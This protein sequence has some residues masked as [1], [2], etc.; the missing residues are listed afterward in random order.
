M[1]VSWYTEVVGKYDIEIP[2]DTNQSRLRSANRWGYGWVDSLRFR[3]EKVSPNIHQCISSNQLRWETHRLPS[4]T[5]CRVQSRTDSLL[6]RN[7]RKISRHIPLKSWIHTSIVSK[8]TGSP[9]GLIVGENVGSSPVGLIVGVNVFSV[10]HT[11]NWC[12]WN[13]TVK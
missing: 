5:K 3:R 12:E 6:V 13:A 11:K 10:E 7:T 2:I 4:W 9:V 1:C 8:L